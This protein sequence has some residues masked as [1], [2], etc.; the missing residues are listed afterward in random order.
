VFFAPN[1]IR[2]AMD[3]APMAVST[4]TSLTSLSVM[5]SPQ[6]PGA[7]VANNNLEQQAAREDMNVKIS[8]LTG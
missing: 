5:M 1:H 8:W 7:A 6:I 3:I 2:L 4:S